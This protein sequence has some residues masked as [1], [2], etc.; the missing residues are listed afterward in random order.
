MSGKPDLIAQREDGSEAVIID[1]KTGQESPSHA[2]Q[3]MI[4]LY[5]IPRA[6]EQY[7]NLKPQRAGP[8]TSEGQATSIDAG[9]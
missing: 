1:A 9:V 3:V 8:S 5:A 4:Y 2:V 7:R 6:L